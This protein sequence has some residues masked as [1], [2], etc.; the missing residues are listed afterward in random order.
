MINKLK[1]PN[2]KIL[3][4]DFYKRVKKPTKAELASWKKLPFNEK[5]F[6]KN[7]IGTTALV[8]EKRFSVLERL[9]SRPTLEVHGFRGGFTGRAPRP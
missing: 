2:G 5:K 7:E 6:M 1:S 8:G 4:P 3:I 9:W